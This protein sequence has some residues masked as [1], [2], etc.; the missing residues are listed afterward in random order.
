MAEGRRIFLGG[1][2]EMPEPKLFVGKGKKLVHGAAAA[3][4][5]LH[6]EAAGEVE[7]AKF[8]LPDEVHPIIAPA[9]GNLDDEFLLA[10]AI[11][12]PVVGD[13]D[14]LDKVDGVTG[15]RRRFDD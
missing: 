7:S 14:L 12:C 2:V 9:A 13:D 8:L 15:K 6:V 5:H 10:G 3:L 11:M 1:E 4:W